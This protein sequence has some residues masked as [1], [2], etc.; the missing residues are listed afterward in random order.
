MNIL[1]ATNSRIPTPKAFGA[2]IMHTC[3]QFAAL[4]TNVELVIPARRNVVG[5]DAFSYFNVP[6]SFSIRTLWVP[7]FLSRGKNFRKLAFFADYVF[8]VFG[9][10]FFPIPTETNVIYL[11]DYPLAF[12]FSKRRKTVLE[13]HDLR[14]PALHI[15]A[16]KR[17]SLVVAISKGVKDALIEHGIEEQ[18][19]IVAPDG[20][21]LASFAQVETQAESRKRLGI[22]LDKKVALYIGRLDGWKGTDTFFE[23]GKLLPDDILT[24]AIGGEEHQLEPLRL[25]YPKTLF[26]GPRPYA[27]VANN[28]AAADVLVLPNSGRDEISVRY[29]SPLKLFT[30]MASGKP[31]VASDLPALREVLTDE[32]AYFFSA[33]DSRALARTV[34]EVSNHPSEAEMRG[35]LAQQIVTRY[36]WATRAE[37]IIAAMG[38]V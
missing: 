38:K 33:D 24:V 18:K 29:T 11:R 2:Q 6:K 23:A 30:Y 7:D 25:R 15:R 5:T 37:R 12:C 3:A 9:L 19:I 32:S 17:V 1:Y 4:G 16:A 31:I 14:R 26:L 8:F 35:H 34:E 21:D 28:E 13:V 20:V 22:P 27:E 10:L 36:S